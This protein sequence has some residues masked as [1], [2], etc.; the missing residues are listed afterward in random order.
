VRVPVVEEEVEITKRPVVREE[1]R[2][3]KTSHEDMRT[4]E[5]ET[6]REEAK[7]ENKPGLSGPGRH[8]R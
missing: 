4:A 6:R 1:V 5:A 8:E 3:T 7:I 2:A